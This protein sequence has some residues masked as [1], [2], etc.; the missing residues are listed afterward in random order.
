MVVMDE[1]KGEE[2]AYQIHFVGLVCFIDNGA[3]SYLVALPDATNAQNPCPPYGQVHEH[4]PYLI[5][6]NSDIISSGNV[7]GRFVNGCFIVDLSMPRIASLNFQH[8]NTSGMM[9]ESDLVTNGYKW[10]DIDP[11]FVINPSAPTNVITSVNIKQGLLRTRVL[12]KTRAAITEVTILLVSATTFVVKGD[13]NDLFKL[14]NNAEIVVANVA[15]QWIDDANYPDDDHFPI[16]YTLGQVGNP[17]CRLPMDN[18]K[19]PDSTS[20]HPF[21]TGGRGLRISCANTLYP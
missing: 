3:S 15:P 4:R 17:T 7:S 13:A 10:G 14:A 18:P 20:T 9:D 12:P 1:R 5:V 6:R 19:I 8:A 11:N 16:Y 2:M 21:V